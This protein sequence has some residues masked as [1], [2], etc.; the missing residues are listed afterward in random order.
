M[1]RHAAARRPRASH[2]KHDDGIRDRG[3][4]HVAGLLPADDAQRRTSSEIAAPLAT[5]RR[6]TSPTIS[7]A[8]HGASQ[9]G[10]AAVI[11]RSIV[12]EIR[13]IQAALLA[14]A[15]TPGEAEAMAAE[16]AETAVVVA[17]TAAAV[18]INATRRREKGPPILICR[19]SGF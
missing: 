11:P 14:A 13:S 3:L 7:A 2:E 17:E 10:S 12:L 8:T 4:R 18:V 16:E 6:Q 9:A 5:A 15:A 19:K 1:R